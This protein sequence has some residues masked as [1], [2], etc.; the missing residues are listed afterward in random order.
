MLSWE[1]GNVEEVTLFL[2]H[3]PLYPNWFWGF[4]LQWCIN[5]L[6][7]TLGFLYKGSFMWVISLTQ[8]SPRASGP[9]L[10]ETGASF[11]ATA[12]STAESNVHMPITQ[13]MVS[14]AFSQSWNT[15]GGMVGWNSSWVP[16]HMV[17][18][19]TGP[20]RKLLFVEGYLSCWGV[21]HNEGS[22]IWPPFK[23]SYKSS[24]IL[25]ILW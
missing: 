9:W 2:L 1:R 19:P 11:Q 5:L 22:L 25:M 20:T 15:P 7:W 13:C 21:G 4:I 3:S 14:Y 17:L 16:W 23:S 6:L 18:D 10:R 8:Y 24:Q 12:R